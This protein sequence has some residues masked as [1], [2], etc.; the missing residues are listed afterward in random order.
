MYLERS[1]RGSPAPAT[2]SVFTSP[3]LVA[4][5][6]GIHAIGTSRLHFAL[7]GGGEHWPSETAQLGEV[8]RRSKYR[9]QDP[10][11]RFWKRAVIVLGVL[12]A[13]A[14]ALLGF[15]LATQED[16]DP[17][18][19]PIA[20]E[21][22]ELGGRAIEINSVWDDQEAVVSE[23]ERPRLY[24]ETELQLETLA[25]DT[26]NLAAQVAE[27]PAS[28]PA[29]DR[30]ALDAATTE[31]V[32]GAEQMLEGLRVPGRTNKDQRL[33][34]LDLYQSAVDSL[35]EVTGSGR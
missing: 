22:A 12:V 33:D 27:L 7:D 28:V 31:M 4:R 24:D 32:R 14:T 34:A 6:W 13:A 20:N 25:A 5:W 26:R 29:T 21:A 1:W 30:E 9:N 10:R 35:L 2:A 16:G 15:I 3:A 23:T 19:A 18:L 11:R 17:R 8:P